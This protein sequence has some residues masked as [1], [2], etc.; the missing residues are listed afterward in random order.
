[1]EAATRCVHAGG[2]PDTAAGGLN[3]PVYPSTAGEYLDRDRVPYQRYFNTPNQAAVVAKLCALEGAEDGLVFGSGM[4]AIS[5]TLL[6]L[7]RPGDRVV[8]Q[9]DLYGGT[10]AFAVELLGG[11]GVEVVEFDGGAAEIFLDAA[12]A[13]ELV[14][15]PHCLGP[16]RTP[17]HIESILPRRLPAEVPD[18]LVTALAQRAH[19]IIHGCLVHD[20]AEY[21]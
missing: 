20:V 10:H 19:R 16:G 1:M 15:V 18:Q 8:L 13:D 6:A 7:A 21:D 3:S 9:E 17:H 5:T 4:A 2:L 11:I 12:F 14:A